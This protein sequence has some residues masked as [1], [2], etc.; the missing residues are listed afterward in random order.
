MSTIMTE[1]EKDNY[2]A[3]QEANSIKIDWEVV[4][5]K[6]LDANQIKAELT[7]LAKYAF[8]NLIER[9]HGSA[10]GFNVR[11]TQSSSNHLSFNV[12]ATGGASS[13]GSNSSPHVGGTGGG[14]HLVFQPPQRIGLPFNIIDNS[15]RTEYI[16]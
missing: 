2:A 9:A 12:I 3:K 16:L 4:F 14:P 5:E 15:E 1:T 6:E 7:R 11:F 13:G 10:F 8:E